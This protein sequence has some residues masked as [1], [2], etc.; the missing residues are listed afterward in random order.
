[1]GINKNI[2]AIIL[3]S[4]GCLVFLLGT[5]KQEQPL[6]KH[7]DVRIEVT[8]STHINLYD[9]QKGEVVRIPLEEYIISCVSAE[10]PASYELEALK[11]QAVAAR[12]YTVQK[13]KACGGK[14]CNAAK[15]SDVC[16]SSAHCQAYNSQADMK[17]KWNSDYDMYYNKICSAVYSTKGQILTYDGKPIEAFYHASSG[18]QTENVENVYSESRRYLI[19]VSSPNEGNMGKNRDTKIF[20][21]E[22]F[23]GKINKAY[24]QANLSGSS[25]QMSTE[26]VSRYASGRVNKIKVGDITLTGKQLRSVLGLNSTNFKINFSKNNIEFETR[27]YGHGVGMSQAGANA[28]AQEGAHYEEILKHYYTGVEL[29]ND[30][31]NL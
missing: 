20:T 7:E 4:L 16:T 31:P 15:N 30:L 10:M 18:G 14:G 28:M 13:L 25:V 1:M 26:V 17:K 21:Y 24:P 11:A 22:E 12:T 9:R 6:E 8:T 5:V 3:V 19:S 27:G 2:T 23:A 29:I